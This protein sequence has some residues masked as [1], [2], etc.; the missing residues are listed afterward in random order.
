MRLRCVSVVLVAALLGTGAALAQAPSDAPMRP[1]LP[2]PGQAPL[3]TPAP[4]IQVTSPPVDAAFHEERVRVLG[5][6]TSVTGVATVL[7]TVNGQPAGVPIRNFEPG[8]RYVPVEATVDLL[9][10][11]NVIGITVT[12][13]LGVRAVAV[14][15][16]TRTLEK[17]AEPERW[18][19]VIGVR[20]YQNPTIPW[21]R[22]GDVD[23]QAVAEVL[24]KRGGFKRSNMRL[25]YEG[26][27]EA[28]PTLNNM[29]RALDDWLFKNAGPR[30]I[31]F[32]YFAGRAAK[33]DD[34]AYLMPADADPSVPETSAFDLEALEAMVRRLRAYQVLMVLDA[35]FG[36]IPGGFAGANTEQQYMSLLTRSA[37]RVV[38]S[39]SQAN[40]EALELASLKHG[41][42]TYYLLRGLD[43][44]ADTDRSGGVSGTELLD[45]L[46]KSIGDHA[47]SLGTRQRP[48]VY[49]NAADMPT[50]PVRR[51]DR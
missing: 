8:A 48:V 7:V 30:D 4:T 47:D 44:E 29:K 46:T 1:G 19:V 23:A 34:R 25:L 3:R 35:P 41:L 10:G 6:V 16:V 9:P 28:P 14:R 13:T 31:V 18:A 36:R 24:M 49:G 20:K 2:R 50:M 21:R 32:I 5:A 45:H 26:S 33:D 15:K 37:G 38:I 22:F 40:E 11:N 17:I 43:G 51:D 42:F 39:A 12:D 27:G